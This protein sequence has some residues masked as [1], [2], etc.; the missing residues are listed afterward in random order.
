MVWYVYAYVQVYKH[1]YRYI[2]LKNNG[3]SPQNIILI[4]IRYQLLLPSLKNHYFVFSTLAIPLYP[5]FWGCKMQFVPLG[6]PSKALVH[7]V[8]SLPAASHTMCTTSSVAMGH[9][10]WS[11]AT[12]T[13]HP[14][15]HMPFPLLF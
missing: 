4:T 13:S 7:L 2:Y 8:A 11:L 10:L 14:F 9:H 1:I 3:Y 15:S 6:S 5:I 12:Q